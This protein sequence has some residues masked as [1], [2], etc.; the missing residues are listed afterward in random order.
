MDERRWYDKDPTLC[1]AIELLYL[2]TDETKGKAAEFM[3]KLQ[4]VVASDIIEKVY[5]TVK[6]YEGKGSRWYDS[7]PLMIKA[8]ELLRVAPLHIQKSAA[9]KLLKALSQDELLE[10]QK[11]FDKLDEEAAKAE[12]IE[13]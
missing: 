7:D 2:S 4:E 12:Q 11:E 10:L 9:K 13:E 5:Q 1:E 6:K 8:I 3:L